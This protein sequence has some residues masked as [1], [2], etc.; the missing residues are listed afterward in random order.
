MTKHE[1]KQ[2]TPI[3]DRN[4]RTTE[5]KE[6]SSITTQRRRSTASETHAEFQ[7]SRLP[8]SHQQPSAAHKSQRLHIHHPEHFTTMMQQGILTDLDNEASGMC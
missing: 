8:E 2:Q 4:I 6:R 1:P 3:T 5:V 7:P